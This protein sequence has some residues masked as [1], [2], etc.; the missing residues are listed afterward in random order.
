MQDYAYTCI[1]IQQARVLSS[2]LTKKNAEPSEKVTV[3]REKRWMVWAFSRFALAEF[4]PNPRTK[5]DTILSA[6]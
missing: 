6:F 2:F 5:R 4:V 1:I 3:A